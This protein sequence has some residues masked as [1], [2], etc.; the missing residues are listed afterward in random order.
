MRP[1]R[2]ERFRR[3]LLASLIAV[4]AACS[5]GQRNGPPGRP[6][7]SNPG[8]F[9]S[10]QSADLNQVYTS[11]GLIAPVGVMPFVGSVSFLPGLTPDTTLMLLS[12]SLPSRV[13]NFL[14]DGDQ[15][16]AAYTVHVDLRQGQ[17]VVQ[18]TDARETVRVSTFKETA[19]T[20]ES[21]IWQRYLR[22]APGTYQLT[23]GVKDA[24]AIRNTAQEVSVVVPAIPMGSLSTP[25]PVYEAIPRSRLDSL[26]RLLTRPRSSVSFSTDSVLPVYLESSGANGPTRVA[27][28]MVAD[29]NAVVWRDTLTLNAR[30]NVASGAFMVPVRQMGIGI[31]TLNVARVGTNDTTRTHFFVTLGED[32]P[33]AS[34]EEMIRYLK[35]FASSDKLKQLRDAPVAARPKAWSDFLRVTD[36]VPSTTENEG[37][38]D[39]FNRI[40]A[41]NVRFKDDALIGWQSDRGTAYVGLGEPDNLYDAQTTDP[42]LRS[43]QQVWEYTQGYRLR[44]VF[45]DNTGLGRYR[46]ST[47]G[48]SELESA[49]RRKLAGKQ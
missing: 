22:V 28:S 21:V 49:I 27:A 42:M 35:Y 48:M 6:D 18:Q 4:L 3:P 14:R 36:P 1:A 10:G 26:P 9:L 20:D 43:R 46:L 13:F 47:S 40:R 45:T 44:L 5:S 34:F 16:A 7:V 38:R 19:R 8:G 12:V 37:L 30:G 24:N 25:I 41:A 29:G 32:L 33:I 31:V 17:T 2:L 15:Y 39:Y 11:M 23:V